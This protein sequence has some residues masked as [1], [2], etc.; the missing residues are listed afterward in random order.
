MQLVDRLQP[1]DQQVLVGGM[2][3]YGIAC[4][5]ASMPPPAKTTRF[6]ASPLM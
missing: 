6:E 1:P 2:A 3:L 4:T 5:K